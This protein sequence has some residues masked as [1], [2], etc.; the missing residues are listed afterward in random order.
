MVDGGIQSLEDCF[1]SVEE[2]KGNFGEFFNFSA[3]D[4]QTLRD[5]C[6]ILEWI[7]LWKSQILM[8]YIV[9]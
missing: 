9:H 1:Q 7:Y 6:N 4:S 2:V 8:V 3:F 5:Q